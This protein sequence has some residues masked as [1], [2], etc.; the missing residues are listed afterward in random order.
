MVARTGLEERK[1]V[2]NWKRLIAWGNGLLVVPAGVGIALIVY[3]V[4]RLAGIEP[5]L[6]DDSDLVGVADVIVASALAGLAAWAVHALMIRAGYRRWW[7]FVGSTALAISMLGPSYM[8]DGSSAMALMCLH[9]AVAIVLIWGLA[10]AG[11]EP[12]CEAVAEP[13]MGQRRT[14]ARRDAM[15]HPFG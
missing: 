2:L 1:P 4:I 14:G 6:E 8:A 3:G 5:V 12:H 13:S 15:R 9:F 11:A 10:I 7:P